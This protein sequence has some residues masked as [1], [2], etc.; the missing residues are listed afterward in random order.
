MLWV[1]KRTVPMR[2]FFLVTKTYV[3]TNGKE[4]INNFALKNFVYL[5]LCEWDGSLE[6]PKHHLLIT[7]G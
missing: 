1:L 6:H 3:K 2:W 5:N 7:D 4:N